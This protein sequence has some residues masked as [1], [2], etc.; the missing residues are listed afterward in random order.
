MWLENSMS[1][2]SDKNEA[3][4]VGRAQNLRG[5]EGLDLGFRGISQ[6]DG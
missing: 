5:R 3:G 2:E 4:Q 6:L 1:G